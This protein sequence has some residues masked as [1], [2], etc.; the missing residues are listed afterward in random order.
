M[1][2]LG[3]FFF[4]LVSGY[5]DREF[6]QA[7]GAVSREL[8]GIFFATG[9]TALTL[10]MMLIGLRISTGESRESMAS[11]ILRVAKMIFLF[12][13]IQASISGG[14][15]LQK[16]IMD[17]R[18]QVL[19]AFKNGSGSTVYDDLDSNLTKMSLTMSLLNSVNVGSDAGM[20]DAKSRAL[21]MGIFGQTA[22]P[23][24]AGSLILINELG[25]RIAVMLA[26]IF[27]AA[28][29]F[30]RTEGMF[31]DWIKFLITSTLSLGVLSMTIKIMS[32]LSV[33]F[34][35]I[36]EAFR[37]AGDIGIL[38]SIPQLDE[39]VMVASFG[40]M[41]TAMLCTVPMMVNKVMAAGLD[42]AQPQG[43]G[44]T[45]QHSG[46]S[47]TNNSYSGNSDRTSTYQS[48]GAG[49]GSGGG[50][51]VNTSYN[52]LGSQTSVLAGNSQAHGAMGLNKT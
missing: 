6:F 17:V 1:E 50:A 38:D 31:Y 36:I 23:V 5:I 30:R 3:S 34:F 28:F 46:S 41:M 43:V 39:S 40:V 7:S 2:L 25:M 8:G 44:G 35:G 49:N 13:I 20:V 51:S 32:E 10:Y 22:P 26:P 45:P 18:S 27:I 24:V 9:V 47:K 42:Y 16:T 11:I 52:N 4:R 14:A 29:M 48:A 33:L 19:N 21:S 37:T 15:E 12:T